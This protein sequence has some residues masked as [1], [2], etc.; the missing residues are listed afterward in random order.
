MCSALVELCEK[1]KMLPEVAW[2]ARLGIQADRIMLRRATQ[3]C[4]TCGAPLGRGQMCDS[5]VCTSNRD[6]L[7]PRFSQTE[8]VVEERLSGTFETRNNARTTLQRL[9]QRARR[10]CP[11]PAA[12]SL[13][14]PGRVPT[15]S[16]H[17][18]IDPAPSTRRDI[19]RPAR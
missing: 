2:R 12:R 4:P 10:A 9:M 5:D 16:E 8:C 17:E 14:A 6:T 3:R 7:R 13:P 11:F 18:R 19:R 15:F 1:V